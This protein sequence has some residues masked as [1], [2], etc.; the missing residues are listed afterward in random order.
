[1]PDPATIIGLTAIGGIAAL[2]A[3]AGVIAARKLH[4]FIKE[5]RAKNK[6]LEM[7]D[8]LVEEF[9]TEDKKETNRHRN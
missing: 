8:D 7:C 9:W 1:M 3:T 6:L 4:K 5:E 2:K